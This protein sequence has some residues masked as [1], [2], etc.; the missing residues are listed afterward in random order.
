[1]YK[2]RAGPSSRFTAPTVCWGFSPRGPWT[3][4]P[5]PQ[6]SAAQED[7][8]DIPHS[9]LQLAPHRE[10]S[11]QANRSPGLA[12]PDQM[13]DIQLNLSFRKI[14]KGFQYKDGPCYIWHPC[15]VVLL[16]L[17][18]HIAEL[19][20]LEAPGEQGGS[21]GP[22]AQEEGLLPPAPCPVAGN[23]GPSGKPPDGGAK[24]P[25]TTHAVAPASPEVPIS[26]SRER[27]GLCLVARVPRPGSPAPG[28]RP[29]IN[30][31]LKAQVD[32]PHIPLPEPALD[33]GLAVTALPFLFI[34]SCLNRPPL[35][36]AIL[37]SD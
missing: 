3:L 31:P 25:P 2:W 33:Q 8:S 28:T 14:T 9:S 34:C 20:P 37:K 23:A 29:S 36:Q 27:K 1:L 24:G 21:C 4:G 19:L 13:T 10:P 6:S 7:P 26:P 18:T 32:Y 12:W 35:N 30:C 11:H 15:F 5:S 22:K 17:I 16:K